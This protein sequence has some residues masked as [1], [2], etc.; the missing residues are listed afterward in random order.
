LL[1]NETFFI[2]VLHVGIQ[3]VI[4]KEAVMAELAEWIDTTLNLFFQHALLL[5]VLCRGKVNKVLGLHI[6]HIFV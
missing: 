2:G 6:Q 1:A 5:S 3:F 4:A